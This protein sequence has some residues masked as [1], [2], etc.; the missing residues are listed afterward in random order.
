MTWSQ[1]VYW[2]PWNKKNKM[3]TPQ[4]KK[5]NTHKNEIHYKLNKHIMQVWRNKFI[6][7]SLDPNLVNS[8]SF[9]ATG[10]GQGTQGLKDANFK[11]SCISISCPVSSRG[12]NTPPECSSNAK[13]AWRMGVPV[14]WMLGPLRT[15]LLLSKLTVVGSLIRDIFCRL[16]RSGGRVAK[17]RSCK[18]VVLLWSGSPSTRFLEKDLVWPT[19]DKDDDRRRERTDWSIVSSCSKAW[20]LLLVDRWRCWFQLSFAVQD[21]SF[22]PL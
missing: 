10:S 2:Q 5:K 7:T 13:D 1:S 20:V 9:R 4:K 19:T 16:R 6:R 22:L 15:F 14:V 12:T 3:H 17:V 8:R 18:T 11:Y 21:F